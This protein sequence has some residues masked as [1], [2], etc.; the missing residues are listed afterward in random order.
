MASPAGSAQRRLGSPVPDRELQ[1]VP[2]GVA[3]SKAPS[4]RRVSLAGGDCK[5]TNQ[6]KN[7][8]VQGRTGTHRNRLPP[9]AAPASTDAA[10][11][12][13]HP[14]RWRLGVRVK[15]RRVP[16]LTELLLDHVEVV[17]TPDHCD[18]LLGA[19]VEPGRIRGWI[20][21][22]IIAFTVPPAASR[23]CRFGQNLASGR[24]AESVSDH[25]AAQ[26]GRRLDLVAGVDEDLEQPDRRLVPDHGLPRRR[27]GRIAL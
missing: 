20:S 5:Q 16:Q 25:P 10:A 3:A 14:V 26:G 22:A 24:C 6:R 23:R 19:E 8:S 13:R 1:S 27:L 21:V 2:D 9:D 15:A 12:R 7:H 18:P 17:R 11:T 4:R